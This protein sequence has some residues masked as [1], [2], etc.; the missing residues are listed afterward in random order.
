MMRPERGAVMA[1]GAMQDFPLR[2]SQLIG[3]AEREHG[4]QEI[5]SARAARSV[6][7]KAPNFSARYIRIA[8]DSKIRTGS[9]SL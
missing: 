6:G 3:H 1:L 2:I 5:V 8:P 4:R 7:R 9:G